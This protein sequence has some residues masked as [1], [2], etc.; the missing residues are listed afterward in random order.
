ML[1]DSFLDYLRL[2]RCYSDC[3]VLAYGIDLAKFQ[4]YFLSLDESLEWKSVDADVIRR[5]IVSLMDGGYTPASVNRK[6]SSLRS[7]YK[8]LLRKGEIR[9]N[10][11]LRIQGPKMKKTLPYFVKE[12][13]MNRLLDDVD[14][15]EGFVACR[16]KMIIEMFYAT[17]MRLSELVGLDDRNVDFSALQLKVTGKSSDL[18]R[19]EMNCANRCCYILK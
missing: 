4:E 3:T 13:D 16:D 9:V 17:G 2:E 6:L 8:F 12:A 11:L 14:F 18:Y 10:P 19:L 7:F 5:W 15:G 1:I